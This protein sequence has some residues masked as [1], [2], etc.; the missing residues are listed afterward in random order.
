LS[1]R[2]YFASR[3]DFEGILGIRRWLPRKDFDKFVLE[4]VLQP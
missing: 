2:A 3:L 1:R 4:D